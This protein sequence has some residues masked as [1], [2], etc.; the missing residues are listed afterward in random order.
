MATLN[1]EA[2]LHEEPSSYNMERCVA[3]CNQLDTNNKIKLKEWWEENVVK[4]ICGDH[5]DVLR[6]TL[7]TGQTWTVDYAM[8]LS[9]KYVSSEH[10]FRLFSV[11]PNTTV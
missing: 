2:K 8:S 5:V 3:S 10:N 9:F 7:Q 4:S 1:D 11:P 6:F